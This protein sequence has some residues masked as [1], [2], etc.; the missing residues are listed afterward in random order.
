LK[1]W[2]PLEWRRALHRLSSLQKRQ[3]PPKRKRKLL[4]RVDW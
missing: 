2:W 1:K 3:W 4:P